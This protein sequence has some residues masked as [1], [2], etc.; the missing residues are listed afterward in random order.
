VTRK[1]QSIGL[2][3]KIQD[4]VD[5]RRITLVITEKGKALLRCLAPYQREI[6]DVEFGSLTREQFRLLSEILESLI[7]CGDKAVALQQYK[8]TIKG[9]SKVA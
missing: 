3:E 2:V 8:S 6:N 4:H 9:V 5:R 1:L 7:D